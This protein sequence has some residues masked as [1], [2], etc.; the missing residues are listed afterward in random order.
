MCWVTLW[1]CGL[2]V[3]A[4]QGH[5]LLFAA[6]VMNQRLSANQIVMVGVAR[7]KFSL[8]IVPLI[9]LNHLQRPVPAKIF[10][11]KKIK[12]I[13]LFVG[14]RRSNDAV[15]LYCPCF[16]INSVVRTGLH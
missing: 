1:V 16:F 5:G 11:L 6:M 9:L 2:L 4:L 14:R 7:D 13:E 10:S 12:I 8:L 15:T 3:V